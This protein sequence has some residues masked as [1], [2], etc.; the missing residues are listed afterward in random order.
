MNSLRHQRR[1]EAPL[2]APWGQA[3]S[4]LVRIHHAPGRVSGGVP[5]SPTKLANACI[6]ASRTPRA[7]AS[8]SSALST[9]GLTGGAETGTEQRLD[10]AAHRPGPA[11]TQRA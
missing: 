1:T 3:A 5:T 7:A 10:P 8:G 11:E 2:H 6:D 9:R 4:G